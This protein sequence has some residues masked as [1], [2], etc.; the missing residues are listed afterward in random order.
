MWHEGMME[1]K[2]VGMERKQIWD[3]LEVT[4]VQSGD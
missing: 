1:A 4:Q 2:A 3:I